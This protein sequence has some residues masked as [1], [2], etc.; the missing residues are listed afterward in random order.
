M[1]YILKCRLAGNSALLFVQT[2]AIT[3]GR[4]R[5]LPGP[6]GTPPVGDAV[7]LAKKGFCKIAG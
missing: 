1:K 6:G 3:N 4:R 5:A 2:S 7:I